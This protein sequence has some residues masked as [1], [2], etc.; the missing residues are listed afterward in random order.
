M[1]NK[2]ETPCWEQGVEEEKDGVLSPPTTSVSFV[3]HVPQ[4]ENKA[5]MWGQEG[6]GGGMI[7]DARQR[8]EDRLFTDEHQFH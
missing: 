1:K 3:L 6:M 5:G 8:R 4:I 7:G 2:F